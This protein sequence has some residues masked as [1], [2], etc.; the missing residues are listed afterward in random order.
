[1][2]TQAVDILKF[3]HRTGCAD[4]RA[5]VAEDGQVLELS[6]ACKAS[7]ERNLSVVPERA[8]WAARPAPRP[9]RLAHHPRASPSTHPTGY[10]A[11]TLRTHCAAASTAKPPLR[12]LQARRQTCGS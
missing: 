7:E 5:D 2:Q 1:M 10:E 12:P 9:R 11:R 3:P 4:Y 8:P 6:F